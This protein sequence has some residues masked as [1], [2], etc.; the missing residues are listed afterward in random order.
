MDAP[1]FV[2][3]NSMREV[4]PEINLLVSPIE[5]QLVYHGAARHAAVGV[6]AGGRIVSQQTRRTSTTRPRPSTRS[7]TRSRQQAKQAK[8]NRAKV[9]SGRPSALLYTYGPGAIMD[10]PQ[11]TIMP[12]GLDDWDRI[13]RA[14]TATRRRST[15]P[16][17]ARWSGCTCARPDASSGR[18]P[19][20]RSGSA[21]PARAMTSACPPGCSRSGCAAPAATCSACC[22]SSATPT[23][24]R[25][26]PTWPA[27]ST[28]GAPGGRGGTHKAASR[29]AV[30]ARYLLAC[31]DGPPGRVPLRPVGAPRPAV[32]EGRVP[33]AA[34]DRPDRG[35]GRV[36]DDPLRVVRAAAADER[37]AG[38]GGRG[39]AAQVPGPPPAPGRVRAERLRP[40]TKLMLVGASNLWFP[41]THS[42]IVMP[43]SAEEKASDLA[44]QIRIATRASGSPRTRRPGD[45]ARRARR[46]GQRGTGS[47]P[48]T[49]CARL[50]AEALAPPP[51]PRSRQERLKSWDPVDL[52]VPEWRYLQ[53][54]PLGEHAR[55]CGQRPDAVQAAP[56]RR[57]CGR[58]SPGCSR[59]SGCARSTRSSASP[60][61]TPSTGSATCPGGWSR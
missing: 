48:T 61:S 59:W 31:V 15:R 46:Q 33:R 7:A 34:D 45:A 49:S 55:G 1:P 44:D 23:P 20:S 41:A 36:G 32:R 57:S 5:G 30:P 8:H 51:T 53:R 9:G 17:C 26:A 6:P 12:T 60:G 43:E 24:T 2:V 38:R 56:R 21:S 58:R 35:Q 14:A 28:S 40:D 18:T 54:D 42:I 10:L 4:Q 47:C 39:Q 25:S 37:G 16:G 50:V 11:F 3:A 27:S 22:P 13:W 52:L 19:G 29:T